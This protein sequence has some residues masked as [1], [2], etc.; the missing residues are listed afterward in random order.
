MIEGGPARIPDEPPALGLS[1]F[2]GLC[3]FSEGDADIF[4]GREEVT[5]KLVAQLHQ[6]HLGSTHIYGGNLLRVKYC[7]SSP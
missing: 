2:K 4:F 7:P 5:A 1:P 3:Y 6:H